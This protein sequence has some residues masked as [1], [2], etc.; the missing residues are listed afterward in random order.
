MSSRVVLLRTRTRIQISQYLF[1]KPQ[2]ALLYFYT[3]QMLTPL[4][5]SGRIFGRREIKR[6]NENLQHVFNNSLMWTGMEP[7]PGDLDSVSA[8]DNMFSILCGVVCR[9]VISHSSRWNSL[10][11]WRHYDNRPFPI[12]CRPHYESEAK[13]K[14]FQIKISVLCI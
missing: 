4:L 7:L 3:S 5:E 8:R 9:K 10:I 11:H 14:A 12:C 1:Y 2:K 13:C 6:N